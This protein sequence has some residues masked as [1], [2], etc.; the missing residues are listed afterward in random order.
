[1]YTFFAGSRIFPR[2]FTLTASL[3]L[4]TRASSKP[5]IF[6]DFQCLCVCVSSSCTLTQLRLKYTFQINCKSC[7]AH[8]RSTWQRKWSMNGENFGAGNK[9][10]S[11]LCLSLTVFFFFIRFHVS[12]HFRFSTPRRSFA[13]ASPESPIFHHYSSNSYRKLL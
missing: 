6:I 8:T 10:V 3:L 2:T 9:Y 1:M 11:R 5:T 7:I 4:F 13:F 12:F